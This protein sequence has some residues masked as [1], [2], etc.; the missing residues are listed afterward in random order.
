MCRRVECSRC[1]KP[2][3]AGCGAH[4][5]QVLHGVPVAARC[6]C[7]RGTGSRVTRVAMLVGLVALALGLGYP[8]LSTGRGSATATPTA[9]QLVAGGA[10]LIDVRS[11]DEFAAGHI[12]D[13]INVPVEELDR[14]LA[15]LGPR[16][17]PVVLYCRSGRRSAQA[18]RTLA[19]AGFTAVHDIGAMSNW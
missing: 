9:R 12:A 13:A 8:L 17:R 2:S 7:P 15:E 6:S 3:Y 18:A 10:Q 16:E 19:D 1:G 5:E 14:R 4:V 11:R